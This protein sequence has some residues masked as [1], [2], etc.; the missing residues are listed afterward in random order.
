VEKAAFALSGQ[1]V[2]LSVSGTVVGALSSGSGTVGSSVTM[3]TDALSGAGVTDSVLST[4]AGAGGGGGDRTVGTGEA[5]GA[6]T[7]LGELVALSVSRAVSGTSVVYTEIGGEYDSESETVLVL[8]SD[9]V[10]TG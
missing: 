8:D 7:S 5:I 2:A 9:L 1:K 10:V 4:T 3:E 6:R